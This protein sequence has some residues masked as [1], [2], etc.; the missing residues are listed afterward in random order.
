MFKEF[1][2]GT[3]NILKFGKTT[4]RNFPQGLKQSLKCKEIKRSLLGTQ[5]ILR[6]K[7]AL[8]SF[9]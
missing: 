9:H 6:I 5:T 7:K 8:R 1:P 4:K 2:V 3:Q